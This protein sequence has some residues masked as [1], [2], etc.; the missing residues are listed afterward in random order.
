[1][2]SHGP[3]PVPFLTLTASQLP[4]LVDFT[5]LSLPS[6]AK[7]PPRCLPRQH[8]LLF[9]TCPTLCS[10]TNHPPALTVTSDKDYR[11]S[12]KS[13]INWRISST[14]SHNLNLSDFL[15][16]VTKIAASQATQNMLPLLT[17][18]P[19]PSLNRGFLVCDQIVPFIKVL[20]TVV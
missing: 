18:F 10:Q 8:H 17:H 12:S 13:I 19:L 3:P 9:P 20:G 4:H 5:F 7:S 2:K 11:K 14:V 16:T 15:C 6:S 1:M